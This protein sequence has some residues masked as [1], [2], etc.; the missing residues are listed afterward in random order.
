MPLIR[1][2]YSVAKITFQFQQIS[3]DVTIHIS[4]IFAG[5]TY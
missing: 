2:V 1:S 3:K 4:I 5:D